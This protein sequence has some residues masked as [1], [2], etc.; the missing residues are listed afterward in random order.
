MKRFCLMLL[1]GLSYCISYAQN[2]DILNVHQGG[3]IQSYPLLSID[4]I[5][6]DGGQFVS[7]YHNEQMSAYSINNVDSMVI[8][9]ATGTCYQI[10]E[11][12]L[13]GW[14]D[15]IYY[16]DMV[17]ENNSF[18]I[19]SHS[20]PEDGTRTVY[21]DNF[22]NDDITQ[23]M[24]LV[25]SSNNEIHDIFLAGYQFE[26]FPKEE[27]VTFVAY[28]KEG[29]AIDSFDV[30]YEADSDIAS[31]R[32]NS[33]RKAIEHYR[34]VNIRN[35]LGKAGRTIWNVADIGVKLEDGKYADILKDYLI[36]KLAGQFAK[37]F[38]G[39]L[40]LAQLI[41]LYLKQLY[42]NNKNWFMGSASIEIT[43]IKR[44]SKS[45]ISVEGEIS[46]TSTIP[47]TRLVASEYPNYIDGKLV[48]L[49]EVPNY[50]LY[51]VAEGDSGQPGLYLHDAC[52]T[53]VVVSGSHFSSTLFV[54]YKPGK[55]FYFRPFLI[56]ASHYEESA[57]LG[58]AIG[59]MLSTNI[60]YGSR[61]EYIDQKPTCSTGSV[62]SKSMTSAVVK[63]AYYGAEGFEC[64]V[65]VK[66]DNETKYIPTSSEDGERQ[67][68][69]TGLSPSTTYLY[70][71]YID[72]DEEPI[73]GAINT[74]T[75]EKEPDPIATTGDYS[76]VT[77]TS[78]TV[79]CTYENVPEGGVC[80]VEYTWN[81]GSTKQVVGSSNGT[82]QISL[83]G[84]SPSTNYIYCAYIEAN[85]QTY[86]GSDKT[87]TTGSPSLAGTWNCTITKGTSTE[88]WKIT[89]TED[90]NGSAVKTDGSSK[91]FEASWGV[92]ADGKAS[93]GFA[94]V[95]STSSYYSY[96]TYN[97]NGKVDNLM[98]PS[99]IQGD[100]YYEIGN[101]IAETVVPLTFTM[102]K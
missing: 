67:I 63:C 86:Y 50:V 47:S 75:T 55:T 80:G 25:F 35:F 38:L 6:H 3:Y 52:T 102:S 83:S 90:H 30:P 36:G 68:S 27:H 51:G 37:S 29:K 65:M 58:Q 66:S 9:P 19:V 12:Q 46:N 62:V 98:S 39:E 92:G 74:F 22:S 70:C 100:G 15:G 20:D 21:L 88:S 41:D 93:V 73:H 7:I 34:I 49:R 56:P 18:Y 4:S 78:A 84:L 64:G 82:Q 94:Y 26:A 28:D 59:N 79:T 32:V 61:K 89:L 24:A 1:I 97:L 53:P 33:P 91:T 76:N 95:I 54:D 23:S 60:R 85:G 31:T 57:D 87:F 69:I 10:P 2:N 99:Q 14:D 81:G 101:A 72:I 42:E 16:T 11:E 13:N 48:Y 17:N 5:T 40:T 96:Q 45:T 71:A 43:S 44:T 77:M 8:R